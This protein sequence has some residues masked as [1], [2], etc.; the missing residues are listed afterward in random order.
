MA[1]AISYRRVIF[2]LLLNNDLLRKK[3]ER[4]GGATNGG[5]SVGKNYI[6]RVN[7]IMP[8]TLARCALFTAGTRT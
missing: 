4:E 3:N 7:Y 6:M 8:I 5:T 1:A 2:F